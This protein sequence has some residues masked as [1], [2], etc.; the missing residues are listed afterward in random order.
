MH[1]T[2]KELGI[3]LYRIQRKSYDQDSFWPQKQFIGDGRFCDPMKQYS[4]LYVSLSKQC[5]LF[6][7][8]QKPLKDYELNIELF[9]DG[10]QEA[11][12]IDDFIQTR[13][14]ITLEAQSQFRL[15]DINHSSTIQ[16]IRNNRKFHEYTDDIP[17]LENFTLSEITNGDRRTTQAISRVVFESEDNVDGILYSSKFGTNLQCAAIFRR[18]DTQIRISEKHDIQKDDPLF[19]QVLQTLGYKN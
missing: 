2:T 11:D 16:S 19:K 12:P 1:L 10:L 4:T 7:T 18:N 9:Q 15:V 6:E 5:A 3:N 14:L 13:E 17:N 8:I